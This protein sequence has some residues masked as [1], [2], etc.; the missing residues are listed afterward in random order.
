MMILHITHLIPP[1][2]EE[3]KKSPLEGRYRGVGDV[4]GKRF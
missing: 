4:K 2:R 3:I 1:S